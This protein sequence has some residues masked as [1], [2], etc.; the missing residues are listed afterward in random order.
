MQDASSHGPARRSGKSINLE[1]NILSEWSTATA[2][3]RHR[4]QVRL[5]AL[6]AVVGFGLVVVPQLNK[7]STRS[8]AR[9]AEARV[10]NAAVVAFADASA[11]RA[12]AE[13]PL[14]QQ[15]K[16]LSTSQANL[17][18]LLGN[19]TLVIDAVSTDVTFDVVHA[20]VMDAELTITCKSQAETDA[21]GRHFVNAASQGPNVIYAVQAS[22]MKSD[23]LAPDGIA[24][25]FIKR[26]NVEP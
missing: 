25:D 22:T 8:A 17:D 26:V 19:L 6:G 15:A 7:L 2:D 11:S 18:T 9:L 21:A 16:M 14:F 1:A 24:F 13:Q 20:E 4:I 10:S 5:I 12:K 23:V 3:L